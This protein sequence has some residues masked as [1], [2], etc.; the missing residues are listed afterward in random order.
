MSKYVQ[1]GRPLAWSKDAGA[2]LVGWGPSRG[3][4]EAERRGVLAT[5]CVRWPRAITC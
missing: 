1:I 3:H 2:P 5:A 4:A